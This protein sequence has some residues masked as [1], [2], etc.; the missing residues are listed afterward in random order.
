M[1]LTEHSEGVYE[2][3]EKDTLVVFA[4]DL[5]VH[6]KILEAARADYLCQAG[7]SG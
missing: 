6:T 4:H 2:K 1:R 5:S 7:I 3:G